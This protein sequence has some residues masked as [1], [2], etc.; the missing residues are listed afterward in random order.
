MKTRFRPRKTVAT[1]PT[2]VQP[3]TLASMLPTAWVRP[4]HWPTMSEPAVN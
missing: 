1:T 3:T 4:A 2:G